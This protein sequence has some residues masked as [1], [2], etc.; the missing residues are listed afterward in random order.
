[1]TSQNVIGIVAAIV[2][3]DRGRLLLVRKH[4]ST[5]FMLPGGKPEIGEAAEDAL[6]REIDEELGCA[7]AAPPVAFGRFT[8]AAVNEPGAVVDARLYRIGLTAAPTA[9]AEIA[10][11][12]W[13]TLG[14]DD[15]DLAPLVRDHVVRLVASG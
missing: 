13:Y 4:G 5:W 11:L 7:L 12:R 10:E 1:M 6:A 15:A 14:S 2:L 3:D 9:R 8:A